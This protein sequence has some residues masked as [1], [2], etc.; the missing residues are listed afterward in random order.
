MTN[1]AD[2]SSITIQTRRGLDAVTGSRLDLILEIVEDFLSLNRT[3]LN[4]DNTSLLRTTSCQQISP[5]REENIELTAQDSDGH[6]IRPAP[7]SK[8]LGL[9][10][11]SNLTWSEHLLRGK[12][13]LVTHA[14]RSLKH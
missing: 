7:K 5:N 9:M 14:K 12:D 11:S 2:D 1:Y 8:L 4:K 13:S 3:K 6:R 10:L